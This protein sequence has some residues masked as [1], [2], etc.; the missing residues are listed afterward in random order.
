MKTESGDPL[1]ISLAEASERL[2]G[3]KQP[4]V[5]LFERGDFSVE[6]FAPKGIDTQQPHDRDEAYI[7]ASGQG[8][9]RRGQERVPFERGDFLFVAAGVPHAFE[10][11]SDGFQV[12]VL[13]SHRRDFVTGGGTWRLTRS[14]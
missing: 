2:A 5:V 11:F 7:V 4:F 8:M 6:L 3:E 13:F 1:R 12:W 14:N 9:F 10:E